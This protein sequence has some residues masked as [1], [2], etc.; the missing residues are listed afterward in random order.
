MGI[1]FHICSVMALSHESLRWMHLALLVE[2]M[3]NYIMHTK[4]N[5]A[6]TP[7]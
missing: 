1:V 5:I 4:L 7:K 6:D 2:D 3:L